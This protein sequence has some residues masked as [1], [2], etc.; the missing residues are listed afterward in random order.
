MEQASGQSGHVVVYRN[1]WIHV[2]ER[3]QMV[4]AVII[5][6]SSEIREAVGLQSEL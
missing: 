2:K 1:I 5:F 4:T 6:G 3:L